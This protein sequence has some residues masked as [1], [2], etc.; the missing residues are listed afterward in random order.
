VGSA[1]VYVITARGFSPDYREIRPGARSGAVV[2]LQS[3]L[4]IQRAAPGDAG[5]MADRVWMRIINPPA[6]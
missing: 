4:S 3:R 2:W 6:S 5:T 1:D